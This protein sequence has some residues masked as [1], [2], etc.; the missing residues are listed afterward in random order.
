MLYQYMS[1]FFQIAV[2]VISCIFSEDAPLILTLITSDSMFS[3]VHYIHSTITNKTEIQTIES[4]ATLYKLPIIDRYCCYVIIS[5][6]YKIICN[7]IWLSD[8]RLFY[9]ASIFV[10]TPDVFN[11]LIK[12]R[13]MCDVI[14]YITGE[15]KRIMKTIISKQIVQ[16]INY[17]SHQWVGINPNV[18]Y[19]EIM[20]LFDDYNSMVNSIESFVKSFIATNIILHLNTNAGKFYKNLLGYFYKYK[21]GETYRPNDL[22]NAK[23]KYISLIVKRNWDSI[24]K[25][26]N[27]QALITLYTNSGDSDVIDKILHWINETSLRM[28]S[29]WT[30]SAFIG[31]NYSAP[32][33]SILFALYRNHMIGVV[34]LIIKLSVF[35]LCYKV[36]SFAI[37]SVLSEYGYY[38]LINRVIFSI[39]RYIINKIEI[40]IRSPRT[41]NNIFLLTTA[42]R[43]YFN[44]VHNF[45]T[46][47]MDIYV[48]I[49]LDTYLRKL[50]YFVV[51]G[52]SVLSGNDIRHI[53]YLLLLSYI[54]CR[55][56]YIKQRDTNIFED[57][58]LVQSY[59][60]VEKVNPVVSKQKDIKQLNYKII[61]DYN[62]NN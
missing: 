29:I 36:E 9:C 20:P 24:F 7:V 21:T 6:L 2:F 14:E 23:A 32:L 43:L 55:I 39:V 47:M 31:Y 51:I 56:S 15:K 27:M 18:M 16:L 45:H 37:I 49:N 52:C 22:A 42:F 33:L 34:E 8:I 50:L 38:L 46:I 58:K 1:T 3:A 26:D 4:M 44:R 19:N 40:Y 59:K 13:Y 30:L 35:V 60:N 53:L 57:I 54:I 17:T 61:E 11:V 25:P 28:F 5:L 10:I 12:W 41:N 48:L 62:G